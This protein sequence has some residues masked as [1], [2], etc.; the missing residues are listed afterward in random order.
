MGKKCE[1]P[2][3]F[4][5]GAETQKRLITSSN[6]ICKYVYHLQPAGSRWTPLMYRPK[7]EFRA[8]ADS[9][10]RWTLASG[11]VGGQEC[12]FCQVLAGTERDVKLVLPIV[13]VRVLARYRFSSCD[14]GYRE[15]TCYRVVHILVVQHLFD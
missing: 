5:G 12:G 1:G 11:Q 13:S 3:Q 6:Y 9:I 2:Y 15:Y 8:H 10:A 4:N 7:R 14:T